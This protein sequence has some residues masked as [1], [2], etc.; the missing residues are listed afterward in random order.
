VLQSG[1]DPTD[2]MNTQHLLV[3]A[4]AAGSVVAYGFPD[5]QSGPL[6]H[7]AICDTAL[8][9]ITRATALVELFTVPELINNTVNTSPGVPRLGL[10]AY[11][12]WSEALVGPTTPTTTRSRFTKTDLL[13]Y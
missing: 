11:Q 10:P 5:C 12:W 9:P 3:S 13:V 2:S 7:N 8:D 4:L 1:P 6:T